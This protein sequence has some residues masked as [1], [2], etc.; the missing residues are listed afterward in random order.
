MA[1]SHTNITV[2]SSVD[3]IVTNALLGP[4]VVTRKKIRN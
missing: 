4:I 2:L 3:V 1:I